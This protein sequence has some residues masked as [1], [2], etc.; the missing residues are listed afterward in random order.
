ML[1]HPSVRVS[2]AV[3]SFLVLAALAPTVLAEANG[4]KTAENPFAGLEPRNI[5]PLNMSGR[6]A[7]VEGIPGDPRIIYV[8]SASGG[9]WKSVD[10]GLHF[11]PIF[12]DQPI[13]SIGDLGLAPS[14]PEVIYAGTGESNVRNSVSFGDGVYKTTDGGDTWQHVGLDDTRHISRVIVH[15]KDPDTAWVAAVGHIFGPNEE[16]GVFR[17]RDGGQTWDKV[18]YLDAF[19]GAADLDIDPSNPN[20]LFATLWRFERKPWTMRSGSDEGGV[21][22]SVDGGDTWERLTEGL[23]KTMGRIGVKVA[24][25]N[26]KVVYVI[27]ES[28]DG[29]LFRSDDRGDTF[30]QV[31]DDVQIVSRGFYYTDLRVD[32]TDENR[33]YAVASRLF[34]SIDGGK[35]FERIAHT[36]HIDFHSL[37]IDPENP[38]RLWVG[39]D[40]GIAVSYDRGGVWEPIRNLPLGQAYQAFY[41][42]REPF[43]FVGGGFQDNGTWFG[44]SRTREPAGV[45]QDLWGMMSFGD[46]YFVVP[47]H[48]Q[49]DLYLSEYQAGGILRTDMRT[50]SLVDVSPQPRRNDGGPVEEIEYRFNWNSPIIRSP[51]D[52]ETVYFAGNVVFKTRDFGD[53]WEVISPDLTTDDPEKQ[54]TAGGPVWPENTTAEYHCTIISFAESPVEA[55]ELW[56]GTDDGNLQL[57]RDGGTTWNNLIA[58]VPGVPAH[59]PVSH[60]EPSAI[61]AGTVYISFDRHMFDD[62]RPHIFKT[63]DHGKTWT[64]LGD[65]IADNAWV[66]VVREDPRNPDV[67]YAGTELG[68][69]TSFDAGTTWQKLEIGDFPTVS[70]HDVLVHPRENDLILGTHGRALWI[71]DDATALQDY[72]TFD[73]GDAGHL[74]PPRPTLRFPMRF[75]RYGMGDKKHIAPNPP[76][77]AILTYYLTQS[78]DAKESDSEGDN[79]GGDE[80]SEPLKLEILDASGEVIRTLDT[81]ALGT[82]QGF[83]RVAWDL[84]EDG[85]APRADVAE[86]GGDFGGPA[87]GPEVLPGTY[88]VRLTVTAA[89]GQ[90]TVSEQSLEVRLD[91]L[92]HHDPEGLQRQQDMARELRDMLSGVNTAMRGIDGLKPQAEALPKTAKQLQR[93]LSES[94][95]QRLTDFAEGLSEQ[96]LAYERTDEKPFWS[97]GPKLKDRLSALFGNIELAYAAPTGAQEAYFQELVVEYQDALERWNLFL[98]EDLTQLNEALRNEALPELMA[99]DFVEILGQDGNVVR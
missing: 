4:A 73:H 45:L 72:P 62:F 12:D 56:V 23:P 37:W 51:H 34:T 18:L 94:L 76:Y 6:V 16:R 22:R 33:V 92:L 7:D 50:R 61:A 89:D 78:L 55:G 27:A 52:P 66:W 57:S 9:I 77:G 67:I 58:N 99:P 46:A 71:L 11:D 90:A 38:S 53:S 43:Y 30:T 32:P 41:D 2:V 28:N 29:I 85:P 10:G 26:P 21:W 65:G 96:L 49:E 74:V 91:P 3:L 42:E 80:G 63:T 69:Y 25:S 82:Q 1:R 44:P 87:G 36:V 13:A 31:S 84:R 75:T 83:N 19:H 88:T 60:V 47:H 40:G 68:L 8:G 35:T 95:E 81:K 48:E 39:Q 20:V 97:Q 98:A 17:T 93:E 5:G 64:R 86:D 24:P 79:E 14:N 59:S 15:P 70:V 54:K